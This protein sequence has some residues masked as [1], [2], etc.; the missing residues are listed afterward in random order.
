M[1]IFCCCLLACALHS[2][3]NTHTHSQA[4]EFCDISAFDNLTIAM[5]RK[6]SWNL[7]N[8]YDSVEEKK[9]SLTTTLC[10]SITCACMHVCALF[11]ALL[12]F[13]LRVCIYMV[14]LY[15]VFVVAFLF[16]FIWPIHANYDLVY[17]VK[18]V[19]RKQKTTTG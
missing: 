19:K 16:A 5:C 13:S 3:Q 10:L 12:S 15:F 2:T 7:C 4:M 9:H 14:S 1:I 11:F 6:I 18:I 8:Y 17:N